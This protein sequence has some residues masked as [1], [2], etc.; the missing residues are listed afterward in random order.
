MLSIGTCEEE[1]LAITHAQAKK[2][3]YPDA[4]EEKK[5]LQQAGVE[6]GK[7]MKAEISETKDTADTSRRNLVEQ[8]IIRQV[9][10]MEVLMKLNDLFTCL[11]YELQ[12]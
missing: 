5:R 12:Y 7:Q 9:M 4:E 10:Q 1:T 11:S 3:T 8:N 6:L 2:A